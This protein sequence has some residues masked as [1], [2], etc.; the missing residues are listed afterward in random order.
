M[1]RIMSGLGIRPGRGWWR[2]A[3]RSL[4][5]EVMEPLDSNLKW[6]RSGMGVV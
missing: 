5:L 4:A 1:W 6:L 3:E 2:S